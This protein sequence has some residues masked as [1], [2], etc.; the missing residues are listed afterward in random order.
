M[1]FPRLPKPNL[2]AAIPLLMTTFGLSVPAAGAVLAVD[3]PVPPADEESGVDPKE[4]APGASIALEVTVTQAQA[5][6][7]Q[8]ESLTLSFAIPE[9]ASFADVLG[10]E[11]S[12]DLS[13]AKSPLVCTISNPFPFIAND[14]VFRNSVK[15]GVVVA[16]KKSKTVPAECPSGALGNVTVEV[17][18][19][20]SAEV[21]YTSRSVPLTKAPYADLK[22]EASAPGTADVGET[23]EVKGSVVNLGPCEAPNV[24]VRTECSADPYAG[25][26]NQQIGLNYLTFQSG[27][28]VCGT[29]TEDKP[30]KAGKLAVGASATF[31]K[32]FIVDKVDLKETEETI[33]VSG[34]MAESDFGD[35][36]AGN[37]ASDTV[38]V[39]AQSSSGCSTVG[40]AAPGGLLG[41]ALA[42]SLLRK[43][44]R[45]TT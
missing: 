44:T 20:L 11:Y 10:C 1:A 24:I 4:L 41:L 8:V 35:P 25:C 29:L 22:V 38:T 9:D 5:G 42:T 6:A 14:G 17:T 43:R 2:I 21:T 37:D 18:S 19:D 15:A 34:F 27:T 7:Q 45:R 23:I 3:M 33:R 36:N 30:C 26:A 13:S 32:L 12:E 39:V 40:G 16:R 31:S 28:G